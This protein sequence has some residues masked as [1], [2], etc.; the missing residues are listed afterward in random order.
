MLS[1]LAMLS[2]GKEKNKLEAD[3]YFSH[4]DEE[5]LIEMAYNH[6]IA[7]KKMCSLISLDVQLD[8]EEYDKSLSNRGKM[9]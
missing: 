4:F 8:K 9:C 7:L 2:K 1:I 3:D 5:V 6:P